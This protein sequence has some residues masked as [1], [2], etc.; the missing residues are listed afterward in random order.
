M[1]DER[2]DNDEVQA[3]DGFI[4]ARERESWRVDANNMKNMCSV[5]FIK[6]SLHN[7]TSGL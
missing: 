7:F 6:Q 4:A 1:G 5:V 3:G 2:K